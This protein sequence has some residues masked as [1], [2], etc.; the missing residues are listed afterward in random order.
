MKDVYKSSLLI[1]EGA[2]ANK[3]LLLLSP[4]L[5][6]RLSV[7]RTIWPR[8]SAL[9]PASPSPAAPRPAPAPSTLERER[10]LSAPAAGVLAFWSWR[11]VDE[12]R[13]EWEGVCGGRVVS[14][15]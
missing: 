10:R 1:Y 13:V 11:V 2:R 6:P 5:P 12:E 8:N 4:F 3:T 7:K 15:F 9:E 14:V